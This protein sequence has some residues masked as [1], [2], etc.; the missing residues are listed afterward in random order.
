MK[1]SLLFFVTVFIALLLSGCGIKPYVD[2]TSK[3]YATL[4][5]VPKSE[6]LI[7]ADDY[8]AIIE[9]FS[10][11][12]KD[13]VML[14]M[15]MTDSDTPSRI[16]KLPVKKPLLITTKYVVT[17]GNSTFTDYTQ[18]VLTPEKNRDY[19]VEY[20][21]TDVDFFQTTSDFHTYMKKGK[22]ILDIPSS[23]IRSFSHARECR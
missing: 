10:K 9:D 2:V 8:Y 1:K 16:V 18:F 14:G 11:G 23:S 13:S 21:K 19:I 3:D 4:Q 7:F 12:C 22:E 15:V 5:L 6:T 20:V 17:S